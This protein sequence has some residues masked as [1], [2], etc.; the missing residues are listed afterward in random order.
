MRGALGTADILYSQQ[1]EGHLY[2]LKADTAGTTTT[3]L[4]ATQNHLDP[5]LP[6]AFQGVLI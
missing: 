5:D 4:N 2:S 1:Q 6:R 3:Q